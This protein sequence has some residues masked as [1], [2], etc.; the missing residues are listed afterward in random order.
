MNNGTS[1]EYASIEVQ[2]ATGCSSMAR[3]LQSTL[4]TW[5]SAR[6][7]MRWQSARPAAGPGG[8]E[9]IPWASRRLNYSTRQ[10]GKAILDHSQCDQLLIRP[11][12]SQATAG[13]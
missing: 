6:R 3:S 8:P 12:V 2:G 5:P 13:G 4:S 9:T 10:G 1:G 7:N 11:T